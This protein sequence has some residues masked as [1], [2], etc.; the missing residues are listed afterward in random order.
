MEG[1]SAEP[2]IIPRSLRVLFE[3]GEEGKECGRITSFVIHMSYLELYK[4]DAFD[5]LVSQKTHE[6]LPIRTNA[7]GETS[8]VGLTRVP[9]KS[10]D[11]WK[12]VFRTASHNRTTGAT[13]LNRASSRSHAMLSIEIGVVAAATSENREMTYSGKINLVDLAGSENNKHTG[14]SLANPIRLAESA[15]INKSLSTLGQ[16]VHA[17]NTGASRVPYRDSNLTRLLSASLGG[18]ASGKTILLCNLAP[19]VKFRSDV[20]N[21]LNFASRT[22]NIETKTVNVGKAALP[23]RRA[24][25]QNRRVSASLIPALGSRVPSYGAAGGSRLSGVGL[26]LG[27]AGSINVRSRGMGV[28]EKT[29]IDDAEL[30]ERIDRLVEAKLQKALEERDAQRKLEEEDRAREK[31]QQQVRDDDPI[32]SS[33]PVQTVVEA[34]MELDDV[35]IDVDAG[36]ELEQSL[37]QRVVGQPMDVDQRLFGVGSVNLVEPQSKVDDVKAQMEDLERKYKEHIAQLEAQLAVAAPVPAAEPASA[38]PSS[39]VATAV[40]GSTSLSSSSSSSSV[41]SPPSSLNTHIPSRLNPSLLGSVRDSTSVEHM[42]PVSRKKTGRAYV[43]LAR[44]F[45]EKNDLATA[46]ALY[47][48]AAVFVPDNAKLRERIIDVEWAVKNGKSYVPSPK[49]Q[50]HREEKPRSKPVKTSISHRSSHSS[51]SSSSREE[52]SKADLENL[53]TTDSG[54]AES[55]S[56]S[57]KRKRSVSREPSEDPDSDYVFVP[58][59]TPGLGF[60]VDLANIDEEAETADGGADEFGTKILRRSPKKENLREL[61]LRTPSLKSP[62]ISD[63][64]KMLGMSFGASSFVPEASE[65]LSPRRVL[66]MGSTGIGTPMRRATSVRK[67]RKV[68]DLVPYGGAYSSIE[69]TNEDLETAPVKQKRARLN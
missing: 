65:S 30:D 10:F 18:K 45:S 48:Q 35:H 40:D 49:R 22:K 32:L 68:S 56:K 55:S 9:I 24:S 51:H 59:S 66:S 34:A 67:T 41:G 31:L 52:P 62:S 2:G 12:N 29:G 37:E 19:G 14:N 21:T 26:G 16:V 6:K 63:K 43:A 38:G 42:S 36:E 7:K 3:M 1:S 64:R 44:G 69:D 8:V 11:D 5:L 46:L 20:L 23:M 58:T 27:P 17:L 61:N 54:M 28:T 4:D 60:G 13:L 33:Y 47:R 53:R 39:N 57:F 15:A 50:H 25:T